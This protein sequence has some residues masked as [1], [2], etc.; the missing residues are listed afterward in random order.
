[1]QLLCGMVLFAMALFLFTTV[2]VYHFY[3]AV[4]D[5]VAGMGVAMVAWLP[6]LV[7]DSLVPRLFEDGGDDHRR[8][9]GDDGDSD[10]GGG[11]A[12][13]WIS[14]Q[15]AVRIGEE[16]SFVSVGGD[17]ALP[18]SKSWEESFFRRFFR[19]DEKST[20]APSERGGA[21]SSKET[22]FRFAKSGA[23]ISIG[24][25]TH[26]TARQRY[27]ATR[28]T[29]RKTTDSE[30][31]ALW[32]DIASS[33]ASVLGRATAARLPRILVGAPRSSSLC[34][35]IARSARDGRRR[36]RGGVIAE[37]S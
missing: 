13:G 23:R 3:F 25:N 4:A 12:K 32:K 33:T 22:S 18:S 36:R 29:Y 7:L 5:A 26:I 34:V 16:I 6:F 20:S 35:D 19:D 1:M 8:V 30:T 15:P 21:R 9:G 37:V 2:M 28:L 14:E 24:A 11:V 27:Y 31:T 10:D 17:D